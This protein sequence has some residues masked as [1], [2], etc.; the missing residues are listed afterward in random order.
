MLQKHVSR[1]ESSSLTVRADENSVARKITPRVVEGIVY[2]IV[3]HNTQM[4]MRVCLRV[5]NIQ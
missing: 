1:Q 3:L 5:K 2:T 4:C